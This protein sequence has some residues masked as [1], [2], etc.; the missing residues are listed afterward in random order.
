MQLY[1]KSL[2]SP[3]DQPK[4]RPTSFF[5]CLETIENDPKNLTKQLGRLRVDLSEGTPMTTGR[6]FREKEIQIARY[7][8]LEREVTDPL[9]ASLLHSIVLELEAVIQKEREI[10][11]R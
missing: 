4:R 10:G 11:Q 2:R 3:E 6:Q 1:S 8:L 9:A 5:Y 7:R